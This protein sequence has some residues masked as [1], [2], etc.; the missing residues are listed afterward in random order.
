MEKDVI[1]INS[2]Q[3]PIGLL[4]AYHPYYKHTFVDSMKELK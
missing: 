1:V 4:I 3:S 2:E